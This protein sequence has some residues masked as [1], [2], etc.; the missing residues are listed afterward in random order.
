MG[1]KIGYILNSSTALGKYANKTT[2]WEGGYVR[3]A[4]FCFSDLGNN[5]DKCG[6]QCVCSAMGRNGSRP[7]LLFFFV[8]KEII[9][10]F[11]CA[12]RDSKENIS[13]HC[14]VLVGRGRYETQRAVF[15]IFV[16]MLVLGFCAHAPVIRTS[17]Y[18]WCL[19]LPNALGECWY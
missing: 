5:V 7:L 18:A 3:G 19:A 1:K 2:G 16:A 9:S 17:K 14:V 10:S 13:D 15:L 11:T 6:F 4:A 12:A 8:F